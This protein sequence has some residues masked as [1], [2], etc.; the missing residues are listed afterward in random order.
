MDSELSEIKFDPYIHQDVKDI[1]TGG[2]PNLRLCTN[3]DIKMENIK[4]REFAIPTKKIISIR[5]ILNRKL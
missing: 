1:P 4:N 5:E 3:E 2:F